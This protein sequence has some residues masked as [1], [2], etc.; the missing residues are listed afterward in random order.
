VL[1]ESH[2]LK[3]VQ[4]YS[5][6][7]E[8]GAGT[9]YWAY[10]LRLMGVDLIAYDSAPVGGPR[11]NRYHLD[12]SPWTDVLAGDLSVLSSHTDRGLFLCWPPTYSSLWEALSFY[13]GECVIYVGDH[14]ARTARLAGLRDAFHRVEVH[15]A[16]AMDPHPGRPPELSVWR[17]RGRRPATA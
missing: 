16:V 10:L 4:R 13:E 7:V 11:E 5:P 8:L 14:G 17:R 12:V 6:L 1:P 9:G 15:P 3:V 2:L